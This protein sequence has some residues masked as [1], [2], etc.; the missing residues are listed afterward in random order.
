MPLLIDSLALE[1]RVIE[2][3]LAGSMLRALR[4][5]GLVGLGVLP[6]PIRRPLGARGPLLAPADF[7]GR[8]LAT[9]ASTVAEATLRALGAVPV[10]IASAGPIVGLDGVEQQIDSIYPDHYDLQARYLTGNIALWPRPLV[11]F[12]SRTRLE[13]LAPADREILMEAARRSVAPMVAAQRRS[14]ARAAAGLCRRGLVVTRATSQDLAA[15]D[16]A[17]SR[18]YGT[19]DPVTRANVRTIE[20]IKARLGVPA[21]TVP[22]CPGVK[23]RVSAVIPDGEYTVTITA[24]DARRAG[25]PRSDDL[26]RVR[27]QQFRL[28]LRAGGFTLLELHNDP[29]TVGFA[30]TFSVYRDRVVATGDNGDVLHARWSMTGDRLRFTHVSVPRAGSVNDYTGVWGTRPWLKTR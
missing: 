11:L 1:Q 12:M 23:P 5:L 26:A 28:V 19:A 17:V 6:G 13:R 20:A 22:A 9:Q 15:L 30:G 7:R 2:S 16:S 10:P 27:S 4:P 8:R 24:R 3:P 21:D 29:P 25:L 18:V 14:D